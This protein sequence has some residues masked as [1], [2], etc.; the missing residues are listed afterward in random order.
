MSRWWLVK[1]T[2][3]LR[4]AGVRV[5]GHVELRGR[6][7]VLLAGGRRI[8]VGR[9]LVIRATQVPVELGAGP[10]GQLVL[11]DDVFLNSGVNL[12]AARSVVIGSRCHLGDGVA[13][14]DTAHHEVE[15]GAGVPVRDVVIGDDVWLARNALVLPGVRIG[16]GSVVAAGAVVTAD[17]PP[18]TL[19]AGVPAKPVRNLRHEPGWRRR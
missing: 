6:A 18:R 11:G 16:D 4:L 2:A 1:G 5:D 13:V 8:A 9:N 12:Y 19:V 17:V 7:G 3:R 15:P 14:A 10:D